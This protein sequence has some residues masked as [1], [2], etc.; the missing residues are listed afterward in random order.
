MLYRTLTQAQP[1]VNSIVNSTVN[2]IVNLAQAERNLT[3]DRSYSIIAFAQVG[4]L[5]VQMMA[6]TAKLANISPI[7]SR[8]QVF[9]FRNRLLGHGAWMTI[10]VRGGAWMTVLCDELLGTESIFGN[11]WPMRTDGA[12][13]DT[14]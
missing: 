4:C 3:L 12:A 6:L 14:L 10:Y 11:R 1:I 8:L 9:I 7:L 5:A 13:V 2:S